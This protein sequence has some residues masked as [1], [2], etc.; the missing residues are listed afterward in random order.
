MH[1]EDYF[2]YIDVF[3]CIKN[4][5]VLDMPLY[6]YVKSP[7]ETLTNRPYLKNYYN[8]ISERY[9]AMQRVLKIDDCYFGNAAAS[10]ANVHIKHIFSHFSNN[11]SK[12]SGMSGK[13]IRRDI[14]LT[15]A[16]P[17]TKEAITLAS[18]NSKSEKIMNTLLRS[19]NVWLCYFFAKSVCFLRNSKL[20]DKIK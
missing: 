20:F 5:S 15:F 16:D 6:H 1:S 9:F 11:C 12:Y 19:G 3:P 7:K 14:K 18:S 17:A 2:F 4:I 13:N 10:A 8:L